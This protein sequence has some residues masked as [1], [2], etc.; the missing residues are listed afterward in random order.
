MWRVVLSVMLLG[1]GGWWGT[2]VAYGQ[3]GSSSPEELPRIPAQSP[4]DALKTFR[5]QHGFTLELVAAEPDVIDPIDAAFDGDGRMY[6][7]EM[8][9]YPFLQEQRAPKYLARQPERFGAIRL[10]VDS[11]DDGRMDRSTIFADG[12]VWPQSVCCYDGGVF[13]IAPPALWYFKDTTGDGVADVKENVLSGFGLANV[14]GLSNGLEWS[15]DHGIY[16]AGGRAGAMIEQG[17]KPLF[18]LN[19]Q[20]LRLNPKTRTVTTVSGGE[21]FGHTFDDWGN[22]YVC[23]N[24]NHL[25]QVVL[26]Q[27]YLARNPQLSA[28]NTVRTIAEE[29]A[30]AKVYRISP[31][32]PWRIMRTARRAAD[33]KF[34]NSLPATELVA[35]GFFTSATGVTVY[36]GGAYPPEF[37]GNVFIGDVG[38][39]L[40]HRKTLEPNGI[41]ML[42]RR[43]EHEVEFLA[44]T[45]NWFRPANFV[46]APDGTLYV[47]DMYRETIEHPA[48][49]PEDMKEHLDLESGNDRGRIYRLVAPGM[50]RFQPPKLERLSAVELVPHLESPHG[51]VRETAH[52][53]IWER[54]DQACVP[55]LEQLVS[56]GAT[57]QSRLLAL[58]SLAGLDGLTAAHLMT[59]LKDAHPRVREQAVKLAGPRMTQDLLAECVPLLTDPDP[60]VRWQLAF[61]LGDR[62]VAGSDVFLRQLAVK[63]GTDADMRLAVLSSI[64]ATEAGRFTQELV[65]NPATAGEPFTREMLTLT[66]AGGDDAAVGGLLGDLLTLRTAPTARHRLLLAFAEGLGRRGRTLEQPFASGEPPAE[67]REAYA[68]WR[69]QTLAALADP[70]TDTP[71]RLAALEILT[72]VPGDDVYA[73]ASQWLG[74]Q[75]SPDLQLRAA[76][77]LSTASSGEWSRKLLEAWKGLGPTTRREA[78]DRWTQ[79]AQGVGVLLDG[80]ES[81][82]IRPAELD[83]DK[84]TLLLAFPQADLKERAKTLLGSVGGNRAEVVQGHQPVL[85]LTGDAAAGKVVYAKICIQCHRAGSEGHQVGPDMASFQNKAPADLLIAILDPNREAQ[86]IYTTYTAVTLQGQVA[87][88]IIAAE[89]A[90]SLTLRRAEGKEETLPRDQLEDLISNGV[91]LMPEG[92]EKDLTP[93]QFADV[94]AFIKGLGGKP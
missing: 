64:P 34:A 10:L 11:D 60:R 66:A 46:N 48:S 12:L 28:S 55:L 47:L 31:P 75:T 69:Q 30:A 24:S 78:I 50:T 56:Q 54:G 73:L 62:A 2:T 26:P 51:W 29:G 88:G 90:T 87:T 92:L 85:S 61:S 37:Q 39:N 38:G 59:G 83:R 63:W 17:A 20:D 27:E 52:R 16:W 72:R 13:V 40:V 7:V 67:L 43:T 81:E 84:Q 86:P 9:D 42:G 91:S 32:E 22:R 77:L 71:Q 4:A 14:Q 93:Q 36:R 25:E 6:V 35:T 74:P 70:A 33:P 57:P 3:A 21:Q 15:F 19:R 1:C 89:N 53:L 79:S 80:V 18:T 41:A 23:N 5:L 82:T 8:R 44:S 58:W 68:S 49:I 94:I 45:D 65:W 76:R